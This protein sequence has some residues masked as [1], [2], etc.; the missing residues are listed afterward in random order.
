MPERSDISLRGLAVG[1]AI[2][3]GGIALSIGAAALLVTHVGNVEEPKIEGAALQT[4]APQDLASFLREKNARLAGSGRVDD[5]HVHIPIE[6]A[7][8][9]LAKGREQ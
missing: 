4:A 7:M 8:R 9:I 6:R 3:V 1:A 5:R 2:I